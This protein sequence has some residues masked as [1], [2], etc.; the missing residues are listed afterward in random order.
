MLVSRCPSSPP[1]NNIAFQTKVK[2]K[3]SDVLGHTISNTLSNKTFNT[4]PRICTKAQVDKP[5]L[6]PVVNIN[7]KLAP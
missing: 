7:A 5:L 6:R 3:S 1:G 4:F 2:G